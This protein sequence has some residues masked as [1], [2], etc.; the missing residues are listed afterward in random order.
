MNGMDTSSRVEED[1]PSSSTDQSMESDNGR[2][3]GN[4]ENGF[5][6]PKLADVLDV[7]VLAR[8]QED[9]MFS[10]KNVLHVL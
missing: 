6:Q 3:G 7:Q 8:M 5:S 10:F 2:L 1:V 4:I 9:S